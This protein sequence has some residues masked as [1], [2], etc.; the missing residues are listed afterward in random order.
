M[1]T[2]LVGYTGFV[3]SNIA[4]SKKFNEYFNSKNIDTI[5]QYNYDV[6][7]YAGVTGTKY[8][9]NLYPEDD[10]KHITATIDNLKNIRT[11]KLVLIST[12]DVYNNP[13][14]KNEDYSLTHDGS[15]SYGNNRLFLEQWVENNIDNY[16]IIRIPALYGHNLKKNFI[17]DIIHIIPNTLQEDKYILLQKDSEKTAS[18]YKKEGHLFKYNSGNTMS[19][20]EDRAFFQQYKF[21]ALNFTDSRNIYQFYNLNNLWN[22]I[23]FTINNSITKINIVSEPISADEIYRDIFG[24]HFNNII[25]QTPTVYDLYTKYSLDKS[26][27]MYNKSIVLE[28]LKKYIYYHIKKLYGE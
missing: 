26:K 8:F 20:K 2:A 13:V 23:T 19:I 17:Y 28:D 9:A 16:H 14:N 18:H 21:N 25:Q 27:Y 3:G 5:G 1:R 7:V 10:F 11:K 12:V 15:L 6:V 22:D 24:Y 4:L